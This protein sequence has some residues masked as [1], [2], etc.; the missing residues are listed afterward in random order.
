MDHVHTYRVQSLSEA[1]DL[2]DKSLSAERATQLWIAFN[3]DCDDRELL[4]KIRNLL[5]ERLAESGNKPL[6]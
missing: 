3:R 1:A 4:E 5:D 6:K 2:I